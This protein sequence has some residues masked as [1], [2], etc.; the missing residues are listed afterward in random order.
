[1][2]THSG[3]ALDTWNC[4]DGV[5]EAFAFGTV[6]DVGVDEERVSFRMDVLHHDLEAVETARFHR[7]NLV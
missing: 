2:S 1:M 7:L 3:L 4:L 5:E 6:F